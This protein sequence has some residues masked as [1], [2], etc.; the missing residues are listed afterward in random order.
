VTGAVGDPAGSA[1][2][3]RDGAL[4]RWLRPVDR[5]SAL[6]ATL[7]AFAVLGLRTPFLRVPM[8]SDEGG[9][10]YVAH[11]WAAGDT[12][13]RDLPFDR[14]YRRPGYITSA[15]IADDVA[16]RTTPEDSIYVAVSEA[17]IYYLARRRAA[18][19]EQLY[20][21]QIFFN[22]R[23]FDAVMAALAQRRPAVVVLVQPP[24]R[25]I[26][27]AAFRQLLEQGY[28]LRRVIGGIGIF[29]RRPAG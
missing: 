20:W 23:V 6:H 14:P 15:L 1:R 25:W 26:T 13:Y 2:A 5:S 16:R 12:L 21:N 8:I 22:R 9:Y 28:A 11:F 10:A 3:P 29:E 4:S 7:L 18:V 17:E 19:A 24:P 27:P